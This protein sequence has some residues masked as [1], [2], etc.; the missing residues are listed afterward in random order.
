MTGE[1]GSVALE[2][3]LVLP[4]VA[5]LLVGVLGST[6]VVTEQLVVTRAARSAARAVAISG[7]TRQAHDVAGDAGRVAVQVH[8]G[9]VTVR[10]TAATGLLGV[11]H[12]VRAVATAPL[13]P[14]AR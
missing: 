6:A 12:T 10:V 1:D 2:T 14:V 5:L 13:E 7:D 11:E 9:V 4:L 8:G 3:V